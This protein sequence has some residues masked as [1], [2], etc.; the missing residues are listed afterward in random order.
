MPEVYE[1]VEIIRLGELRETI[2][3]YENKDY[4]VFMGPEAKLGEKVNISRTKL[5]PLEMA[6]R[7]SSS[8]DSP[9]YLYKR[10]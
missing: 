3:R 4:Q 1:C 10:R 2:R 9:I 7:D 5:F 6:L 8:T